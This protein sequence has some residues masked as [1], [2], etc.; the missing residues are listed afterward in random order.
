V[1]TRI[2]EGSR[3][4]PRE[5]RQQWDAPH[6]RQCRLGFTQVDSVACSQRHR[7]TRTGE[8]SGPDA[9][10]WCA[11]ARAPARLISASNRTA[12]PRHIL[13]LAARLVPNLPGPCM[14]RVVVVSAE[15]P[16]SAPARGAPTPDATVPR[17]DQVMHERPK[18][19]HPPLAREP[20]LDERDD[21]RSA[22]EREPLSDP[23]RGSP[24]RRVRRQDRRRSA[25][26]PPPTGEAPATGGRPPH[27]RGRL[28]AASLG[29]RGS[30]ATRDPPAVSRLA[31]ADEQR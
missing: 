24:P 22:L 30:S 5:N 4:P 17:G 21:R 2:A 23:F 12:T 3:A 11:G 26:P 25:D 28:G 10:P 27:R 8:L 31:A 16:H 19:A 6:A 9:G 15:F 18:R 14:S 7:S 20:F 1:G 13:T 29:R